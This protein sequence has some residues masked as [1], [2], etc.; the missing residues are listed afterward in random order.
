MEM[1]GL[2]LMP[3]LTLALSAGL[4]FCEGEIRAFGGS[5]LNDGALL[6]AIRHL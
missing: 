6:S 2:L 3:L 4:G 1:R 5:V